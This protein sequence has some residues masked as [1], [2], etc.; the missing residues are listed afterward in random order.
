MHNRKAKLHRYVI[1][2]GEVVVTFDL[3]FKRFD[4]VLDF[5]YLN[6]RGEKINHYTQSLIER[7]GRI[8]NRSAFVRTFMSA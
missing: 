2:R 5:K 8:S 7:N 1:N 6:C 4:L 3:S